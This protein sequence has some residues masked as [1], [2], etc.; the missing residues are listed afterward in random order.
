MKHYT[1]LGIRHHGVGS[2]L[3]VQK[4]LE[5]LQ[6]D[7]VMI[8]G[9]PEIDSVL[10]F[11]GNPGLVP[12]VSIM[13]YDEKDSTRSSF[14]PYAAYSPEWIAAKYANKNNIP[15]RSIDLPA[16]ISLT[17]NFR[18]DE[19]PILKDK[20]IDEEGNPKPLEAPRFKDAMSY[21]AEVAGYKDSE[22]W[23]DQ[24]F[25]LAKEDDAKEHFEA[26]MLAMESL[27]EFDLPSSLDAENIYREAYMRMLIRTAQNEMY[28]NIVVIC[29]AWHAPALRDIDDK[30]KEDTKLIKKMPKPRNKIAASWIPWTNGRLSMYSG[31]GAG[32]SSP[33]WYEHLSSKRENT[34]IAWLTRIAEL[35]R[36]EGQDMSSAHVIESYKLAIS[37]CQLRNKSTI[38]LDELNESVL[39]VMCMG[40]GILLEL[41]KKEMIVG[42]K[43]GEVPEDI[44]K[45]PLQEDFEKTIKTLRLE[46]TAEP[47]T[48][49]LD[50]RKEHAVKQSALFHRLNLL[51]IPWANPKFARKDG[52]FK[53]VWE[54]H[55]SPEMMIA[56][57][58]NAYLG[59]T[60]ELAARKKVE[61]ICEKESKISDVVK[62]LNKALPADLNQCVDKL[63]NKIDELSSISS[64]IQD[65]MFTLPKLIEVKRYGDVRKSDFTVLDT[66]ITRLLTKIFINLPMASYGLDDDN[67]N[68]LFELI[69]RL[70]SALKINDEEEVLND[71]YDSLTKVMNQDGTHH[72]IRGCVCRLLLDADRL[73][74]EESTK[75]ISFALSSANQPNDVASWVEGFLRGSGM[76]L[77]YDNRLWNLLYEWVETLDKEQFLNLLPYLRRAFSK[78]EYGERRQIGAKAKKGLS[79]EVVIEIN[80]DDFDKEKALPILDTISYLMGNK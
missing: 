59:N 67:S 40:D 71:W 10:S 30:T 34:E 12:P 27:R 46:L 76:I 33:G 64:D 63:L 16:K 54:L 19:K 69:S 8:E 43:I 61:I 4:R 17:T 79:N 57:I 28:E 80:E 44:P 56:L 21:L 7:M 11:I 70:Q 39:T 68:K 47:K 65:I 22:K 32:I 49:K 6:P 14:Y 62:L 50:L 72:I 75:K 66:I 52:T 77:I 38:S 36:K 73:T 48:K 3:M 24:Q 20:D 25:E 45:V 23:W 15:L 53:E 60:L 51:N 29:G 9:P 58:D 35:F 55:W 13:I 18:K 5:E 78:F 42:E 2:G 1:I 74:E 26:V 31:Y 41:V 37:L